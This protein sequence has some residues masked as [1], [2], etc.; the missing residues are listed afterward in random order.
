MVERLI[1]TLKRRLAFMITDPL[2]HNTSHA[3]K[4]LAII[5]SIRLIPIRVKK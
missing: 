5:E 4:I 1:Q 3:E 2:W